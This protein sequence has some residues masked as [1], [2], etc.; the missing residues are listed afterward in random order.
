[1]DSTLAPCSTATIQPERAETIL[2]CFLTGFAGNTARLSPDG[3][4]KTV[5]NNHRIAIHPSSTLH[6]RK[7]EAIMYHEYVFT[8]KSY[9]KCVSVIQ[10]NWIGEAYGI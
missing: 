1:M 9:G 10:M 3:S 8:N 7:L 6:G 5:T 4:Y 2:R